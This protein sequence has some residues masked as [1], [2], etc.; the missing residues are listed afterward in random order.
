MGTAWRCS[1]TAWKGTSNR[2]ACSRCHTGPGV[3]RL[4]PCE[5]RWRFPLSTPTLWWST[6]AKHPQR[7]FAAAG[8]A[9]V[10]HHSV[11]VLNGN[12][13]L[14]SHGIKRHTPGPV[15]HRE[16]AR[17][18]DV[19]FH[20]VWEHLHAIPNIVVYGKYLAVGGIE[21]D[22]GNKHHARPWNSDHPLWIRDLRRV[23]SGAPAVEEDRASVGI[24]HHYL[25]RVGIDRD[26]METCVSIGHR[27]RRSNVS[28][29]RGSFG[30]R[31][32][33]RMGSSLLA[34]P[35]SRHCHCQFRCVG[36]AI[37]LVPCIIGGHA[38]LGSVRKNRGGGAEEQVETARNKQERS[39]SAHEPSRLIFGQS[40]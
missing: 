37:V 7:C 24:A 38:L 35:P 1:H 26:T 27:T 19:P 30:L 25:I 34:L 20:A 29:K 22:P 11:G 5:K 6:G 15:W 31:G 14:F 39:A 18:F 16:H 10:D 23:A 32:R 28:P 8:F 9:P 3:W 4:I 13:H 12:R 33:S 40:H 2:R 17:R 36:A 21:R